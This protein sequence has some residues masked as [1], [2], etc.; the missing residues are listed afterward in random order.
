LLYKTVVPKL[1]LST[2]TLRLSTAHWE[3]NEG[4]MVPSPFAWGFLYSFF[5]RLET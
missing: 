2:I 5:L 4:Y 1:C 3:H